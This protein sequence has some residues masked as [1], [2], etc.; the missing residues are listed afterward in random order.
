MIAQQRTTHVHPRH[1]AIGARPGAGLGARPRTGRSARLAVVTIALLIGAC[2]SPATASPSASQIA[3]G[4]ASALPNASSATASTTPSNAP[5]TPPAAT[6]AA[7]APSIPAPG[8][9]TAWSAPVTVPGLDG[10]YAVVAAVDDKGRDHIAAT[11]TNGNGSELRYSDSSNGQS[12]ATAVLKAPAGR[13]ELDPQ[14]ALDGTKLYLAYTRVAPTDGG[15]GDDGLTDVGVYIRTRTLPSG[16]W[17]DPKRIGA[18]GDHLQSFR[19]NGSSFHATVTTDNDVATMYEIQTG[20]TL[21]RYTIGD[22]AGQT[23]LRVGD[24]GKGRIAYES[25][26]GIAY[27]M[28]AGDRFASSTIPNSTNGWN[29]ILALG[30]GNLAYVVWNRSYHGIGCAGPGDQPEDGTYFATNAGGTWASSRVTPQVG[31]ASLTIDAATG[32]VNVVVVSGGSAGPRLIR[33][34]RAPG[35]TS[36]AHETVMQGAAGSPVIRAD[37]KTGALFVAYSIEILDPDSD[38]SE[39]HVEVVARH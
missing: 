29:P 33:F 8:A 19:V 17:S 39:T 24:D 10:C 27:G 7:P 6:P 14:L 34:H 25:S 30:P 22:A 23:S 37:P 15:C 21:R 2:Q 35:A 32:E 5:S 18:V 31:G 28:V 3:I 13:Y 38:N 12:W 20:D 16:A 26:K 4:N 11:C 36:W 1:P 9:R